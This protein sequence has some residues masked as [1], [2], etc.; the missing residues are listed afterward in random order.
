MRN[1]I[2]ILSAQSPLLT[3]FRTSVPRPEAGKYAAILPTEPGRD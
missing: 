2:H 3:V 1:H